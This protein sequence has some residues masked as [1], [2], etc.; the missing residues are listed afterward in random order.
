MGPIYP[1]DFYVLDDWRIGKLGEAP[2]Q[3]L[4]GSRKVKDFLLSGA[5]KPKECYT[6][7]YSSICNGGCKNDWFEAEDGQHNYFCS[8]FKKLL[9][10][11]MPRLLQI[12][13]AESN[14]RSQ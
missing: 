9:D 2:L 13:R 4:A 8:S 6:C 12:A 3:E 5:E 1:C 7:R 11:A 14:A 10:Y